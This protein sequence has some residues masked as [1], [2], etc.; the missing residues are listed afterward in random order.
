MVNFI[1]VVINCICIV[2]IVC[3]VF[4]IVFIVPSE[5]KHTTQCFMWGGGDFTQ[6]NFL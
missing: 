4:F 2:F 5:I 3:T 6:V 1:L